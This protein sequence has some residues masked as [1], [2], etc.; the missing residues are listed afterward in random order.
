MASFKTHLLLELIFLRTY[1]LCNQR[2][3]ELKVK[4]ENVSLPWERISTAK[5]KSHTAAQNLCISYLAKR[6][7]T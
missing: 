2:L 4:L 1:L 5:H 6:P 3:E 7:T